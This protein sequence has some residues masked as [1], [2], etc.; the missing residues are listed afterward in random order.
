[1]CLTTGYMRWPVF[2]NNLRQS[3]K[4]GRMA[5]GLPV[6]TMYGSDLDLVLIHPLEPDTRLCHQMAQLKAALSDSIIPISVDV[7]NWASLSTTFKVNI[8]PHRIKLF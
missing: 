5:A 7:V 8:N 4:C 3:L 2:V 6:Y 1:M